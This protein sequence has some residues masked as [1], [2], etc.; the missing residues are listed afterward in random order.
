MANLKL[1]CDLPQN[2]V[3]LKQDCEVRKYMIVKEKKH[4]YWSNTISVVDVWKRNSRAEEVF[5]F[6]FKF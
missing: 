6:S 5:P 4:V 3:D 1:I 2:D